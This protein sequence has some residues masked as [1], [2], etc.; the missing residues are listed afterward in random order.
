M[1][2]SQLIAVKELTV[3]DAS[4]WWILSSKA[5]RECRPRPMLTVQWLS[6]ISIS[7]V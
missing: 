1:P 5:H 6:C 3:N 2:V 7:R 4:S